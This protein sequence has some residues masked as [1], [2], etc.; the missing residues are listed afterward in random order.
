MYIIVII[1]TYNEK[2]NI[3]N[4]INALSK[5]F[6]KIQK[7]KLSILVV[8]DSSPDKTSEVVEQIMKTN[9][10]VLL[11]V[12]DKK[13]GLGAA[14]LDAMNY[15]FDDLQADAVITFDADLS[16]DPEVVVRM[17]QE[18]D[19]GA[20]QVIGT[21]YRKGG[22]IPANWG[23]HRKFLSVF[24][25]KFIS[26][27]Y[28]GTGVSD[29]TGGFKAITKEVYESVYQSLDK[30]KGY[31]FS[32]S[33]NLEPIRKGYKIIEIPYH[34]KDREAGHSKMSPDYFTNALIFVI[35]NR[36]KDLKG[37]RF[38][39]V[40]FAGGIGSLFQFLTF[41]FVFKPIIENANIF[42]LPIDT[43][44]GNFVIHPAALLS[45]AFSIEV[46]VFSSF[47]VNNSWAFNDYKLTGGKFFRRYI[48]NHAVVTGAIII[49]LLIFTVLSGLL[50]R[51]FVL[52]YV[53]QG[54]GILVGLIWNFYF[55]KKI[56]WKVKKK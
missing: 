48:K 54:L 34:F 13:E 32:I 16:H 1:P 10:S 24:G 56:I 53:Y 42:N 44:I 19:K 17:V 41:G 31:T 37:S 52:D 35:K 46:G 25:N 8:D 47:V 51:S 39:K 3:G 2:E 40:F 45:L 23:L 36:I 22:G 29:F 7:H 49:Q 18:M 26:L 4:T 5:V 30:H 27:L 6:T 55:Y 9:K 21:R 11:K 14:Y 33:T 12:R 20:K 15:S 43:Q 50:G 28:I 38:S